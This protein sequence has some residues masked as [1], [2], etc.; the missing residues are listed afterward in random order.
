[1]YDIIIIGM[2]ISG[3]TA[4]IYGSRA[5]K[6]VLMFEGS[7]PGGLINTIDTISNYPGLS[8]I[9]GTDLAINLLKQ[10]NDLAIPYKMEEVNDIKI[11]NNIK[12]V[13]T[14]NGEYKCHNL[15]LAMGRKPK[16]L[17]LD[18]EKDLL[19]RGLSTCAT[20]DGN[21]YKGKD[22]AVVGSGDSALQ[23]TLYLSKVVNKIYLIVRS[24]KF[25]ANEEFIKKVNNLSNIEILFNSEIKEIKE[26]DN[27][28]NQVI[29]NNGKIIDVKGVFI[30]AGFIPNSELVSKLNILDKDGY[31]IV[32]DK[33]ESNINGIYAIGDIIKKDLYQVV[34]GASDGAN[35]ITYI[36][37]KKE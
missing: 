3:I 16:F 37:L 2:G 10:V 24:D 26:E 4:G 29:L 14:N 5:G 27:K 25:K 15:I 8:N 33:Y 20:C 34:T 28:I 1:M 13:I 30:Y 32:N 17:G 6:K 21:F 36:N 18:N 31:V 23:E 9:K 19:G 22:V 11:D 12:I 7:M 35:V